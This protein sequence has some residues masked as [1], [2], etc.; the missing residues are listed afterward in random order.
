MQKLWNTRLLFSLLTLCEKDFDIWGDESVT[1]GWTGQTRPVNYECYDMYFRTRRADVRFSSIGFIGLGLRAGRPWYLG[2]SYCSRA[3]G[4]RGVSQSEGGG[5]SRRKKLTCPHV[6]SKLWLI[7]VADMEGADRSSKS[8]HL[9][10]VDL[11]FQPLVTSL[12][13]DCSIKCS[14]WGDWT[15]M[16][17]L[18][19]GNHDTTA[20]R[21]LVGGEEILYWRSDEEKVLNT[22]H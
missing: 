12:L 20:P 1:I 22:D 7:K 21:G 14:W 5:R 17:R 3:G 13:N 19:G 11:W 8:K 16:C 4:G 18:E 2:W 10:M 15:P 9:N 6:F